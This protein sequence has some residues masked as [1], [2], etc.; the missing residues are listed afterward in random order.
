LSRLHI[1]QADSTRP[2]V[3]EARVVLLDVPCSGTGTLGRH[4]DGRWR[5]QPQD[6]VKLVKLQRRLLD[7]A[8]D[9]VAPGG[10]L[11]YATCSL[12]PEENEE[13]VEAFLDRR[14]EFELDPPRQTRVSGLMSSDGTL[15]VLPQRH[16]MDGAYAAR[17]R[18]RVG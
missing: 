6:L 18:R 9:V 13:Q 12:E 15:R 16:G 2:P 10:W 3:S 11:I 1:V 4:P 14:R 5:L 8:A 17:L 7:G